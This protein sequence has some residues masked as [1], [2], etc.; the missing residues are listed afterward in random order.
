MSEKLRAVGARCVH[1]VVA[2]LSVASFIVLANAPG[3]DAAACANQSLP[4][5]NSYLPGCG[6]YE[7]VTPP[8]KSGSPVQLFSVGPEGNR[9]IVESLGA[10]SGSSETFF[11]IQPNFYEMERGSTGWH[12]T[13]I[14]PSAEVFP[15]SAYLATSENLETSLWELHAAGESE[16]VEDFYV[17]QKNGTFSFVGHE[18]PPSATGGEPSYRA[19]NLDSAGSFLGVSS[20]LSSVLFSVMASNATGVGDL[21]P[22]DSTQLGYVSLYEYHGLGSEHPRLVGVRGGLGSNELVSQCGVTL[23]STAGDKAGALSQDGEIVLFTALHQSEC[24]GSQPAANELMARIG[25]ASTLPISEPSLTL[26][27]RECTGACAE[28]ETNPADNQEAVFQG[29][30]ADSHHIFFLTRQSLVN[31]DEG[32]SGNGQDL[33]EATITAEPKPAVTSLTQ[34]SHLASGSAEVLGVVRVSED[35]SHVYYVAHGVLAENTNGQPGEFNHAVKG[36]DNLYVYSDGGSR[37]VATLCSGEGASGEVEDS[38]CHGSDEEDWSAVDVRHVQ[39]TPDGRYLVFDSAADIT[40]DDTTSGGSQLFEYD[41]VTHAIVRV[42]RGQH[43]YNHDGNIERERFSPKLRAPY[44]ASAV[45]TSTEEARGISTNGST[46][47]FESGDA[48]TPQAVSGQNGCT[49]VY[50]YRSNGEIGDGEV[51]LISDGRD[52]SSRQGERCGSNQAILDASGENAFFNTGS[53][54]VPG[55]IDQQGDIYDARNGG[56][57]LL[58]APA[59]E[60][61]GCQGAGP[62]RLVLP[63]GG[64]ATQ[65]PE[66]NVVPV[67]P[68]PSPRVVQARALQHAL[69]VCRSGPKRRRRS[70]EAAARKRFARASRTRRRSS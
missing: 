64:S 15:N 48:L 37:Y 25:G 65:V 21:W 6:A 8:Y 22:G 12:T 63:S 20:N 33:Y 30:S 49:N 54:L 36:A 53:S 62:D 58:S 67:G 34:I 59:F 1:V 55:D 28:Q 9:A 18:F 39:A 11:I 50:E 17:R 26:P 41:N 42:S 70:C 61:L 16:Y 66:G 47:M 51:F 52:I 5:F 43:G 19:L 46:I 27:G 40:V 13:P 29:A 35:G 4:G 56:G 60:C 38:A 10:F 32:G 3:A 23:G 45:P 57:F 44:F 24:T 7:M 31:G 2:C 68:S 69:K 14:D